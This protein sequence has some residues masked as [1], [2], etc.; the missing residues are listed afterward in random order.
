M[1][2]FS[3]SATLRTFCIINCFISILHI[4]GLIF[5]SITI[6]EKKKEPQCSFHTYMRFMFDAQSTPLA[7]VRMVMGSKGGLV[8]IFIGT[9]KYYNTWGYILNIAE[10]VNNPL[11]IW[12]K[13]IFKPWDYRLTNYVNWLQLYYSLVWYAKDIV[14]S[15]VNPILYDW[16]NFLV[17]RNCCYKHT[18]QPSKVIWPL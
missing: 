3:S 10:V 14:L 9:T 8:P 16:Y 15:Y 6:E 7:Q 5:K 4:L 18:S 12:C 2:Y 17:R 11:R 13:W 1:P